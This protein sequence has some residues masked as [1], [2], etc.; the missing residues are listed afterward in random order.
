MTKGIDVIEKFSMQ[1]TRANPQIFL[2]G[3]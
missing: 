2:E 1:E 3:V